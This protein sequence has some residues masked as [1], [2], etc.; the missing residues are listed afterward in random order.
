MLQDALKGTVIDGQV[1]HA[2]SKNRAALIADYGRILGIQPGQL[3]AQQQHYHHPSGPFA[4]PPLD[5]T[6]SG[7]VDMCD[8]PRTQN[9]GN[10]TVARSASHGGVASGGGGLYLGRSLGVAERN[11]GSPDEAGSQG[12]FT[13]SQ[14]LQSGGSL[15]GPQP[16]PSPNSVGRRNNSTGGSR[17]S[18]SMPSQLGRS[19]LNAAQANR[20]NWASSL[21]SS[22]NFPTT[23]GAQAGA[24]APAVAGNAALNRSCSS[25]SPAAAAAT[26]TP[27]FY[28]SRRYQ[29]WTQSQGLQN[30]SGA[31]ALRESRSSPAAGAVDAGNT[32]A[33][34]SPREA[35]DYRSAVLSSP[36]KSLSPRASLRATFMRASTATPGHHYSRL[37]GGGD[38]P[39][40]A[41]PGGWTAST[42]GSAQN[43]RYRASVGTI[44]GENRNPGATPGSAIMAGSSEK[45]T[46]LT[47]LYKAK[48]E[49]ARERT[50][51]LRDSMQRNWDQPLV[52]A[53][54]AAATGSVRGAGSSAGVEGAAGS[55]AA[56]LG[57][58]GVRTSAQALSS[59]ASG[60]V[61]SSLDGKHVGGWV[62]LSAGEVP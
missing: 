19:S 17:D 39:A 14:P 45:T 32:P 40:S 11:P 7:D 58:G 48:A 5:P 41:S 49:A 2:G 50:K 33:P 52:E 44:D 22:A 61:T 3:H 24:P 16:S 29:V 15:G 18:G 36:N 60:G 23:A 9:R 26:G 20:F 31:N 27:G 21:R 47:N 30:T 56:A 37:G 35:L 54:A 8:A 55:L 4:A 57:A 6:S 62:G 25:S 13:F 51:A 42:P 28:S 10:N 53:A 34:S 12:G 1:W 59:A 43:S 46:P 38:R